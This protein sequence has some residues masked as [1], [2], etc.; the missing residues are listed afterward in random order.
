MSTQGIET[1]VVGG[2]EGGV[3]GSDPGYQAFLALQVGFVAAPILAGLDK[4]VGLLTDWSQ[5]LWGP[6]ADVVGAGT[7]LGVVGVVEIVAGVLV[8]LRPRLGG[9]VVSAWLVGIILNLVLLGDFW[10]V[11]LRDLGL[12][13]GA[14]ALARLATRYDGR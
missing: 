2:S 7:F 10:D 5:Y 12:A 6:I 9:Y 14:F 11:A 4:F 8:A 1:G 3:A 13:I